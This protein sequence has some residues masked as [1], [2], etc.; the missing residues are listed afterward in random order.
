MSEFI[1]VG[2]DLGTTNSC[3]AEWIDDEVVIYMNN[4]QSYI[5]PSIVYI[6]P[7]GRKIIGHRAKSSMLSDSKNVKKEFK[8]EMG[9]DLKTVFPDSEVEMSPEELSAEVLKSLLANAKR[10]RKSDDTIT[11][12]IIT[13]PA[14]FNTA[15]C[16]STQEA[17]K[18]AGLDNVYLL[19]EPIAAS[20]AYGVKSGNK[21]KNFIVYDLGGGTLD[22][23]LIS[24]KN[25]RLTVIDHLG[26]NFI[27]GKDIDTKIAED[28]FFPFLQKHYNLPPLNSSEF[29][30]KYNILL[31]IAESAKI[32]L[33]DQEE[34]VVDFID[35]DQDLD[36]KYFDDTLTLKREEIEYIIEDIIEDSLEMIKSLIKDNKFKIEDISKILLVGGS[37]QIPFLRNKLKNELNIDLDY[38]LNP[39]TVVAQGAAIYASMTKKKSNSSKSSFDELEDYPNLKLEYNNMTNKNKEIVLGKFDD[40]FK[41][42]I[43]EIKIVDQSGIWESGWININN[44]SSFEVEVL[45][46]ENTINEF[47]ISARDNHGNAIEIMNNIFSIRHNKENLQINNGQPTTHS[48]FIEVLKEDDSKLVKLF[49]KN[50]SLP[51]EVIKTFKAA[52]TIHPTDLNKKINIKIWEGEETEYLAV[53]KLIGIVEISSK[54]L[55]SPLREDDNIIIKATLDRSQTITIN[56]TIEKNNENIIAKIEDYDENKR[57]KEKI[58][59]DTYKLLDLCYEM[60]NSNEGKIFGLEEKYQLE[61]E[62]LHQNVYELEDRLE[63]IK[64]LDEP[65]DKL[66]KANSDVSKGYKK[67]IKLVEKLNSKNNTE[68]KELLSK[69]KSEYN[70]LEVLVKNDGNTEEKDQLIRIKKKINQMEEFFLHDDKKKKVVKKSLMRI[71]DN[72][73][74]LRFKILREKQEFWENY[75]EVLKKSKNKMKDPKKAERLISE[76]EAASKSNDKNRLESKVRDLYRQLP[77][78][79]DEIINRNKVPGLKEF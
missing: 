66:L 26:D 14:S 7:N 22:I 48:F 9:N 29:K 61:F 40:K 42:I 12:A 68:L 55:I 63:S 1:N 13:V 28:I 39:I 52:Q 62:S 60:I 72:I 70:N 37:T 16:S 54:D 10:N 67:L 51:V 50:T 15:Q 6:H 33:S 32:N 20:L 5:T 18:L 30:E 34:T 35:L 46:Q 71:L 76:A 56:A 27:G 24:T 78:K 23:A 4:N 65:G 43:C 11:E 47:E 77:E 75:L 2:I 25:D 53:N 31:N 64:T 69:C 58:I 49:S 17:G 3:I 38:S 44:K 57:D 74:S 19:Q 41:D 36:G 8:R 21:N 45:L 79:E 59:E 73:K